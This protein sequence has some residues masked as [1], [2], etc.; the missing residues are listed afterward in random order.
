[1]TEDKKPFE[2]PK[3][4][5][6]TEFFVGIF[7]ILGLGCFAYLAINIAGIRF[8]E[9]NSYEVVAEFDDIS[10]LE[11]GAPVEIAGVP[12]GSVRNIDLNSTRAKVFLQ[13]QNGVPLRDD[14]LAIIRTKGIIGDRYIKIVPGGS[15]AKVPPG[16]ELTETNSAV[17][18]EDIIG[19]I[20]HKMD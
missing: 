12:I 5:F 17:D 19:K 13:I 11:Q 15:E 2:V 14:D 18:F 20:I 3:R 9:T 1:M 16:G 8:F 10:G 7:S 4:T 6:T